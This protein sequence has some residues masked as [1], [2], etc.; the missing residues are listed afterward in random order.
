MLALAR[1][2]SPAQALL[3]SAAQCA[4]GSLRRLLGWQLVSSQ[5]LP[6]LIPHERAAGAA[7]DARRRAIVLCRAAGAGLPDLGA[8]MSDDFESF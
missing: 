2:R 1:I 3:C 4:V 7:G 5:R 8:L 6:A